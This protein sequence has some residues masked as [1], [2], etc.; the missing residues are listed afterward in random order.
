M[1]ANIVKFFN[2]KFITNNLAN[3]LKPQF[4][5]FN[6]NNQISTKPP[7][8]VQCSD[9]VTPDFMEVKN[10]DTVSLLNNSTI[11]IKKNLKCISIYTYLYLTN[12]IISTQTNIILSISITSTFDGY[13]TENCCSKI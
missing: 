11:L 4:K 3:D 7:F 9:Q 8:K 10:S 13:V 1:G 2:V 12:L 5:V 6:F